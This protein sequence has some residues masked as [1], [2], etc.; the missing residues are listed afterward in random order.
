M[1]H[2]KHFIV[3][4]GLLIL[5]CGCGSPATILTTETKQEQAEDTTVTAQIKP[6]PD[7]SLEEVETTQEQKDTMVAVYICGSVNN[8]GVYYVPGTAIK[9]TVVSMA[10][11]FT[12]DADDV[13]VNLAETVSQGEQIYIP[14]KEETAGNSLADRETQGHVDASE[15]ADYTVTDG[16]VDINTAGKAELM[17]LPGIGESK[18]NAIIAYRQAQ[19]RFQSTE[20]LMKIDG[21]KEGIYDKIK[22]LII[23]G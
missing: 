13:Y 11:G 12:E 7:T 15:E 21:I 14:T 23:V 4:I 18:A 22:D 17:T 2:F 16:K 1:Q 5:L 10:G 6:E 20:E 8:P 19:G 3:E 9:E